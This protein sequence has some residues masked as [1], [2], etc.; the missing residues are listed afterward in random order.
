MRTAENLFR[1][2]LVGLDTEI[3]QSSNPEII[4]LNGTV[5]DE[6]KSMIIINTSK[7]IKKIPKEINHWKFVLNGQVV[8]LEGKKIAK[9]PHERLVVK[10]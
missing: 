3:T 7:G 6:T 1:H 5:V 2:E 10:A 8:T 4:G 9:R